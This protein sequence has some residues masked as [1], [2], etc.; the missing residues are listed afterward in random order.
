MVLH[1][2]TTLYHIISYYVTV[3]THV[4]YYMILYYVI[5]VY[6]HITL[7]PASEVAHEAA[8]HAPA[9]GES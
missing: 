1:Y 4:I 6:N 5:V 8:E 7:Y 9:G 2:F 3:L